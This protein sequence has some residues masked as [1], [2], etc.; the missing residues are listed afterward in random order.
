MT[1]RGR[2]RAVLG[3]VLVY[4]EDVD[5]L[6]PGK[7]LN[8]QVIA[9]LLGMFDAR[10]ESSD[11]VVV[12]EPSMT[13]TAGMVG[14]A[15]LLRE[16]LSVARTSGATPLAEQLGVADLVL[17]PVNNNEDASIAGGGSHWSLLAF[18]RQGGQGGKPRFEHYD[19]CDNA[20]GPQALAIA[21]AMAPLLMERVGHLQLMRMTTP[22]QANG[23]DCGAYLLAIAEL[24][25]TARSGGGE[26]PVG[27]ALSEAM[28]ALTP[29]AITAKR[30]EWLNVIREAMCIPSG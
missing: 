4:D 18:R 11:G 23:H 22:R 16:M 8:D 29:Q 2:R 20:N 30:D 7:W 1:E 10:R 13:F 21:R 25:C 5:T 15:E 26:P 14:E 12:L 9:Y 28:R 27:G 24:L 6:L 19:S 3:D 17:M